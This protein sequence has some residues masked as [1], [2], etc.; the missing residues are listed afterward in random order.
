VTSALVKPFGLD[1]LESL[2]RRSRARHGAHI[3]FTSFHA[4]VSLGKSSLRQARILNSQL[5]IISVLGFLVESDDVTN[6]LESVSQRI[7]AYD[8]VEDTHENSECNHG[9]PHS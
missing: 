1:K 3:E 5:H 6:S 9:K 8:Q 2:L 7:Q 4:W